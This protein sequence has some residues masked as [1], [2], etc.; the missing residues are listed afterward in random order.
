[1]LIDSID[2]NLSLA[3][4]GRV[5]FIRWANKYGVIFY[6]Q[7]PLGGLGFCLLFF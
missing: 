1:M 4:A 2:S 6:D 5:G 3:A 7:P